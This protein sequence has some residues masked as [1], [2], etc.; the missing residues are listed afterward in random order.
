MFTF[1]IVGLWFTRF[2]HLVL[3]LKVHGS[4]L[5][6]GEMSSM[7]LIHICIYILI[8]MMPVICCMCAYATL[9]L[10]APYCPVLPRTAPYCP[11]LPRTA[12]YMYTVA[13]ASELR[14]KT[15]EDGR[16]CGWICC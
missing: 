11:V 13:C 14:S 16:G 4:N 15:G 7:D 10:T 9:P 3:I 12:T 1:M 5:V 2:D 6:S 8:P